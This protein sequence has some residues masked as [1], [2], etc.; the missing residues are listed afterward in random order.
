M[1]ITLSGVHIEVTDALRDYT[2]EK[3]SALDKYVKNDM[4]AKLAVELSKTTSHHGHGDIF[5]AEA[6]LHIKGKEI[7]LKTTQDDLYKSIDILKDMLVRELSQNKDK[8]K[9]LFR[10]GAHK[11]KEIMR[12][13]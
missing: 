1:H 4:S 12:L 10:R 11:L 13:G 8:Q 3:M 6:Q 7:T 5:Q 2:I 9:S